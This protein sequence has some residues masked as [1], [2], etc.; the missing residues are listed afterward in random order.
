[1]NMHKSEELKSQCKYTL[2][3]GRVTF[4]CCFIRF[5]WR[6]NTCRFFLC[7]N[8]NE[9]RK[10][11]LMK[12]LFVVIRSLFCNF[13]SSLI[14]TLLLLS[15]TLIFFPN[16]NDLCLR[17]T[18]R[19]KPRV[20][21]SGIT[22]TLHISYSVM[23]TCHWQIDRPITSPLSTPWWDQLSKSLQY[24]ISNKEWP[25]LCNYAEWLL[26]HLQSD[27]EAVWQSHSTAPT[28][29]NSTTSNLQQLLSWPQEACC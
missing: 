16:E 11:W 5:D 28:A 20:L 10:F 13:F 23:E 15:V 19:N 21:F 1:M 2:I 8:E 9:V 4:F 25:V 3:F 6:F 7:D 29:G 24:F 26:I 22:I 17:I 27:V 18:A 12:C 14:N